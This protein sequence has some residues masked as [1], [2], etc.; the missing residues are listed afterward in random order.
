MGRGPVVRD[1]RV[2]SAGDYRGEGN[3]VKSGLPNAEGAKV[4]QKTQKKTSKKG[5]PSASSA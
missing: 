4:T 5:I 3:E 1:G 2:L